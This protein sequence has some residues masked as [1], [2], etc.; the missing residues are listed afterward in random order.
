MEQSWDQFLIHYGYF[1]ILLLLIGGIVGIPLPDEILLTFVGY[2]VY[3]GNMTFVMALLFAF[4]GSAIGIT[5][6][7]FLGS[8]LGLPFLKRYGSKMYITEKKLVLTQQLFR[9]YGSFLLFIGYFIP[10]IRHVTAYLAGISNYKPLKFSVVAYSGALVWTLS[11]ITLGF[12]LGEKWNDVN[13]HLND[14]TPYIWLVLLTIS[15]YFIYIR[16]IK[17]NKCN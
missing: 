4:L 10:G 1:G 12:Q 8:K 14:L 17:K 5:I 3:R 7:Y 16:V 15:T 6:S 13:R 11:F 9:K 2:N